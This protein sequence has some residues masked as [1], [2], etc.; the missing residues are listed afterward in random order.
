MRLSS[1]FLLVVLTYL[2]RDEC[3]N[4]K[5]VLVIRF[6]FEGVV[7]QWCNL[8]TLQLEQSGGALP[9]EH[10]GKGLRLN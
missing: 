2:F 4:C 5:Y 8:L 10:C 1:S 3:P 9:F 7:T 6:D